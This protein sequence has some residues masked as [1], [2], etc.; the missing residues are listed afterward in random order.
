[1]QNNKCPTTAPSLSLKPLPCKRSR[2]WWLSSRRSA[3]LSAMAG[4]INELWERSRSTR[5]CSRRW[6]R[7]TGAASASGSS[8][9]S[10]LPLCRMA[11]DRDQDVRLPRPTAMQTAVLR[12][13]TPRR[14]RCLD[15]HPLTCAGA[16]R[17]PLG[18]VQPGGEEPDI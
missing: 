16:C 4:K 9:R 10:V 5:W 11:R 13:P 7:W 8:T 6:R 15:D 17:Q 18:E 14:Y 3:H 1:M 2:W 12:A